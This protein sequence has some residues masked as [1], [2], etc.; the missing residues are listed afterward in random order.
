MFERLAPV[1]IRLERG[2]AHMRRSRY[3]IRAG[4]GAGRRRG[5][6][7]AR[8]DNDD[9]RCRRDYDSRLRRSATEDAAEDAGTEDG[10]EPAVAVA[11]GCDRT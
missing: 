9:L 2:A 1:N 4:D 10:A 6:R 11:A 3:R 7:L 8:L 5:R